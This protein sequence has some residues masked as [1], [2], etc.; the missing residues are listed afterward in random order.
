MHYL[1][2]GGTGFIGKALCASLLADQ[3]RVTVLTRHVGRA[4]ACL[5]SGASATDTLDEL[6][7]IDVVVNLA[8]ENLTDGRWSDER[9]QAFLDSRIGTTHRLNEWMAAQIQR[10]KT[11]ISGSA[12]GWYGAHGEEPL[13]EDS[14]PGDDFPARL[15]QAWEAEAVK[16]AAL[17]VRVCL[18]R[19]G[20]VLAA[21]GGALG[22]M[23]L[24]FKLG[25]GGPMG[26]GKQWMSWITRH[27]LVRMIRWLAETDSAIGTYNGTAPNPVTNAEF[28]KMLAQ[29]LHR[30]SI[31]RTPAIVLQLMFGEMADMLLTG[32]R[33]LP[34][35]A[36]DEGFRF[37]HLTV[38]T[39]LAAVDLSAR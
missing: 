14:N 25:V 11:M 30:P 15:C 3:H 32:Q 8:G 21:D 23:L 10:P 34:S 17:G 24:P 27:D 36:I 9:K 4:T 20:I 16:A 28:A 22:K 35:R 18:I 26:D 1:I 2:T 7:E 29:S 33:V 37:D 12:I 38:A 31:I 5:P 13:T 6:R 19:T 39:A